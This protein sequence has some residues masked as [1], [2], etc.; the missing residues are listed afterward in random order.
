VPADPIY[1]PITFRESVVYWYSIQ[2]PLH[3]S[4]Y[5]S[6]GRVVV[7]LVFVRLVFVCKYVLCALGVLV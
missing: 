3:R 4:K 6:Q 1:H 5:A 7:C 2:S